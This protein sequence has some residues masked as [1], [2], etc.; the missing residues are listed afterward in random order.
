MKAWFTS[1]RSGELFLSVL[2]IGEIRQGVERLKQRD[3]A[4]AAVYGVWLETLKRDYR[5]R[6]LPVTVDVAETWADSMRLI[7][8]QLWIVC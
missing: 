8:C 1:V 3:P 2:V 4:Q 5:D 6:V 7:L